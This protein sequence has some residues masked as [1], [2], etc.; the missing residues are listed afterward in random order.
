MAK[1]K[2]AKRAIDTDR[3]SLEDYKKIL[4]KA[5]R[6]GYVFPRL[7]ESKKWIDKYDKVLLLRHDVDISPLNALM[8]AGLEH[9]LGVTSTYYI[10]LRSVFY[11]P[12]ASPFFEALTDIKKM[13]HE[14][15]LHYDCA[16]YE[17]NGIDAQKGTEDDVRALEKILGIKIKSVAQHKPAIRKSFHKVTGYVDAYDRKLM[18]KATYI[19]ESGFK[20]RGRTLSELVGA[21]PKIYALI[22]PDTWAY[23]N[24]DMAASYIRTADI[25]KRLIE[26]ECDEFIGSTYEYLKKRE[27]KEIR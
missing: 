1:I 17:E 13:G 23:S 14:I 11:N 4:T 21:C 24:I 26:R 16:F 15:G 25:S 9:A 3:F 18:E 7:S 10:R 12:A 6:E 27:A 2:A 22:H 5:K 20:W 19:S 8:M